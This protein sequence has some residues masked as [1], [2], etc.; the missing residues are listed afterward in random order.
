MGVLTGLWSF[1]LASL[2]ASGAMSAA[3]Q[4][5]TIEPDV[6][7]AFLYNFTRFVEWP[8]GAG[9][10]SQPFRLCLIATDEVL[11][12]SI[13]RTVAGEQVNGRRLLVIEPELHEL[14]QCQI[15][16]VGRNGASRVPRILSAVRGL[17]VLT[18]S[19]TADFAKQGGMIGFLLVGNNVRF[20]VNVGSAERAGLRVS[21]NLL[22]VAS[23][24]EGRLP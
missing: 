2:L 4:R 24:I 3:P 21:A 23:S 14:S 17:P 18:V 19:D 20:N 12:R 7:A 5:P 8:A 13:E 15:V 11:K 22:R 16:F 10:S 6:K 1:A 9:V